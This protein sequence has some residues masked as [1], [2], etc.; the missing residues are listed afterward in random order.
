MDPQPIPV[1]C[2]RCAAR[3]HAGD[4]LFALFGDQLDFTPVP[5]K[6]T[7]ADGWMP[8]AQRYYI[9]AL[10]LTG[11]ERQAA[12]AVGK[13]QFGATQLTR[14]EGNES[15]MAA[16]A[17]AFA[18]FEEEQHRR[19]SEGLLAAATHAGHRHAP[20]PA[21]WS[22]AA[23][24]QLA[25]SAPAAS[26]P[27]GADGELT[28]EDM[29]E[30]EALLATLLEKYLIKLE[31]EREARLRG[32]IVAADF[33]LRQLSWMEVAL[34]VISGNGMAI[35]RDARL[36]GRDLLHIAETD[37]SRIL[38]TARH[39][40]WIKQGDPPR[41]DVVPRHLLHEQDGC[42]VE[43]LEGIQGGP[44]EDR[45]AQQR[46]YD[47]QHREAAKEQIEWEARARR[48]YEERRDR[49]ASS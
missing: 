28:P 15:F 16:R 4:A 7:R 24:R 13:A 42:A 22:G 23:T 39:L 19:H 35:L 21:A 36:D 30:R 6:K 48:D 5:R 18:F 43:P 34:D 11:S 47:E 2:D 27:T 17:K 49:D 3:G 14:A 10:A 12:H 1:I 9:A 26:T 25:L 8:E 40:Y 37:M 45:A 46:R 33:Y 32:E 38:D 29:Q 41:P 44:P 31:A 20:V